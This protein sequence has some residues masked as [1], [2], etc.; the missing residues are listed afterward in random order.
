MLKKTFLY[1]SFIFFISYFYPLYS[2]LPDP[3]IFLNLVERG[4]KNAVVNLL[5]INIEKDDIENFIQLLNNEAQ[6]RYNISLNIQQIKNN[7]GKLI[8]ENELYKNLQKEYKD[9][10]N[11]INKEKHILFP[12][13]LLLNKLTFHKKL[14]SKK[15]RIVKD[16]A[17]KEP[18]DIPEGFEISYCEILAGVLLCALP[19]PACTGAG[20][21]MI[22]DGIKRALN[23][24]EQI[25]KERRK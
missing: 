12:S 3:V 13:F 23:T 7:I 22:T 6:K 10:D 19:H 14:I 20:V 4:D 17:D 8:K 15:I 21:V 11:K 18:G 1:L 16:L 9:I 25:D 24:V 2:S 5:S